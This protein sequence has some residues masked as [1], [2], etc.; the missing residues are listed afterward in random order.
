MDTNGVDLIWTIFPR[1][2]V[3]STS[4][5]NVSCSCS[6]QPSPKGLHVEFRFFF[7]FFFFCSFSCAKKREREKACLNQHNSCINPFIWTISQLKSSCLPKTSF[8]AAALIH[9][10]HG[11]KSNAGV[12]MMSVCTSVFL[13]HCCCN[14]FHFRSRGEKKTRYY[15]KE[16][17][18]TLH[19]I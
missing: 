2:K 7:L 19:L 12:A 18:D 14:S 15:S 11:Q 3:S 17:H 1:L 5:L 13:F 4:V 10:L 6:W 16:N 9:C 8:P